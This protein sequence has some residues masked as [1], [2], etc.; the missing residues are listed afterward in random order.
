MRV[1]GPAETALALPYPQLASA[2]EA[3]LR[4]P[5]VAV[6]PRIVQ[7]LAHGGS[8]FVMPAADAQVAITK[9][10]TF[11]ADNPA[12]GLPG[13]QGDIVVFDARDGR[14]LALLDGPTVTARRT[15]A[16]SLLAARLMARHTDGPLLV[17]GAGVQGRAHLEAFA[18]G[19]G[20]REVWVASRSPASADA[21]VAHARHLGMQARRVDDADAALAHCPLVVST[22][23]AQEVALRAR[24]RDGAFVAAVGAFTPRM[25]E[26]APDVCRHVA[27]TGTLVVDT[28]DADHEAGD[29]IQAGLDVGRITTLSDVVNR[30]AAWSAQPVRS[31]PVFFKSCGWAGWDLAAARCVLDATGCPS[32]LAST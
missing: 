14:R 22:T 29:L 30:T 19:L 6:P 31:G 2:I 11:V 1:L 10:I 8:L 7:P 12:R 28:R 5:Q 21:L 32:P 15:A 16:V 27:D 9:L 3:V 23:S 25:V 26:W 4:D 20:V 24:P 17:V 18:E 13:I